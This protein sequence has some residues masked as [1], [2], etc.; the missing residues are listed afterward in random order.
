[1]MEETGLQ[2]DITGLLG[3]FSEEGHPV[4]LAA[5][6]AKETGGEAKPGAGGLRVGLLP[7]GRAASTGLSQRPHYPGGVEEVQ[8]DA[9]ASILLLIVS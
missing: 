3:I 7:P 9:R 2:V 5:F 6:N 4:V 8:V 1:M